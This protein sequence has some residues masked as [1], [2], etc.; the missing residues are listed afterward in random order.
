MKKYLSFVVLT[1]VLALTGAA[2][3]QEK[4][5][6]KKPTDLDKTEAIPTNGVL[7][8]GAPL[9]KSK[10]V[11]LAKVMK[12]PAKYFGQNRPR[13]RRDRP[14]VQDGRLLA[15]T[16]AVKRSKIGARQNEGSRLF[17]PAQFRRFN[18]KSRGRFLGQNT[19]GKRGQTSDRRRRREI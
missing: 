15:R 14:F 11:S 16:R 6:S 10:K 4:M 17:Y 13:R 12:N 8:R 1:F 19:F 2:F 18:G 5:E 9:G 7:K 3:G